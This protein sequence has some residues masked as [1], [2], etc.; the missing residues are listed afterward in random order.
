M[1]YVHEG[2][3]IGQ[4][5]FRE[6]DGSPDWAKPTLLAWCVNLPNLTDDVLRSEATRAIHDS[7]LVQRFKGNWEHDHC[8]ASAAYHESQRR[9]HVAGHASDC[10]GDTIYSAAYRDAVRGAGHTS[11]TRAL[12]PCT[13]GV[14]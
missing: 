7:A 14:D 13:C 6:Y 5:A 1:S 3:L 8:R 10:R 12:Q 9:H 11:L 4:V 2:D